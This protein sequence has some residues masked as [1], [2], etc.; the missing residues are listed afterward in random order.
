MNIKLNFINHSNDTNNSEIVIFAK[1][2]ATDMQEFAVAW[3]VIRFCGQGENHPFVYSTDSQVAMGDSWGNFSP[4]LK[5]E[6]GQQFTAQNTASGDHLALTGA[7]SAPDE[8]EVVNGLMKGS[9]SANIYKSGS[10][11]AQKTSIAPGMK[12]VFQFTPTIWIGVASEVDE[13]ANMS[14]AIVSSVNTEISL[15]GIA[16]ADIVMTGGGAGPDATPFEFHLEN[17][18]MA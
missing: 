3:K 15:L 6:P 2:T 18:S 1:N 7:S 12:A 5:A 8:I 13:G 14:S 16:S 11:F 4:R 17:V 9:I 10:L